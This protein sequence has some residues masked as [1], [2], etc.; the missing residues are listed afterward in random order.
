MS[1]VILLFCIG[2]EAVHAEAARF[3]VFGIPRNLGGRPSEAKV[4]ITTTS[5]GNVGFNVSINGSMVKS[6]TVN[7]THSFEVMIDNSMVVLNSF[8]EDRNKSITVEAAGEIEVT[9]YNSY[10]KLAGSIGAFRVMPHNVLPAL[11]Q[12]KYIGMSTRGA[13]G[14]HSLMLLVGCENDTV[15][16][17]RPSTTI[18]LP[19]D[20]QNGSTSDNITT[21]AKGE[22]HKI[23]LHHG[24]TLLLK[25]GNG[26]LTGTEVTSNKPLTVIS[27]HECGR[28]PIELGGCDQL[29]TQIPPTVTWGKDFILLPL[30]GRTSGHIYKV[31]TS[32]N[33]TMIY[34]DCNNNNMPNS[35]LLLE[36]EVMEFRTG[37]Y[38]SCHLRADK[39][40]IVAQFSLGE[41]T[42]R[43]GDP[44]LSIVPPIEQ[45]VHQI[46]FKSLA[47]DKQLT[48]QYMN[49]IVPS[50]CFHHTYIKLDGKSI[51]CEWSLVYS[52]DSLTVLGYTCK[53]PLEPNTMHTLTHTKD[54]GHMTMSL[55]GFAAGNKRQ[56]YSYYA[57]FAMQPLN[58]GMNTHRDVSCFIT[59]MDCISQLSIV[60]AFYPIIYLLRPF[61]QLFIYCTPNEQH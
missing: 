61:I 22:L 35:R 52:Y 7:A 1:T 37:S 44:T 19:Q 16:Y 11:D 27:G 21:I 6:S 10:T 55:Y 57:G 46:S 23:V 5:R 34:H 4:I 60:A 42:D 31:I 38:K 3:F 47:P 36:G 54:G 12:Y 32:Q 59:A 9:A 24:Q 43:R 14:F 45:Y 49:I 56:G 26:D 18:Q 40:I 2:V 58:A 50:D 17:I 29:L 30:S 20:I 41:D 15:I 28:L 8:R 39:P 48:Q 13:F 51:L 53:M 33:E 25:S